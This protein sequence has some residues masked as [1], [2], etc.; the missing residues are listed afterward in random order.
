MQRYAYNPSKTSLFSACNAKKA[1]GKFWE[2]FRNI[3]GVVSENFGNFCKISD[4]LCIFGKRFG[5]QKGFKIL[6]DLLAY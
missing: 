4:D 5:V 3:L 6:I 1:F 2:R